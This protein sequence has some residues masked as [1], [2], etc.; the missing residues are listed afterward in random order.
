MN[1][2]VR[3]TFERRFKIVSAIRRYMEEQGYYEVETPFLHAIIG[4]ANA[5]PSS[6]TS[7]RLIATT[8]CASPRSCR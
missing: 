8:T 1:P 3:T 2:E 7:T 5:K 4:G 6:R